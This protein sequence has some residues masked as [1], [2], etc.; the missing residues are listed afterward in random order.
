ME[1]ITELTNDLTQLAL[2]EEH[3]Q[4]ETFTPDTAWQLGTRLKTAVEALGKAVAI[5]IS[6]T[7]QPLFF[8]AMPGTTPDNV[9]W[10]R[11]KKNVVHRFQRSSYAINREEKKSGGTL[12]QKSGMN[13]QD[14]AAAGGCFPVRLRGGGFIGTITVSGLPQRIDH[15]I[16]VE[17]LAAWLNQ[18][19]SKLAL[20]DTNQDL[21]A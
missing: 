17:V 6:L 18:P 15:N 16:I 8:F 20:F 21:D 1:S 5:D 7:G 12:L 2:Q 10:I 13:S 3:L 4:F 11:R 19:L 14:H 9:D